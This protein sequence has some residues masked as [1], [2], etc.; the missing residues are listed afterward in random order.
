MA[1]T[2]DPNFKRIGKTIN[3]S[4]S[5]TLITG[6]AA[7]YYIGF[8][9]LNYRDYDYDARC[10]ILRFEQTC[11]SQLITIASDTGGIVAISDASNKLCIF[12]SGNDIIL[13]H[14]FTDNSNAPIPFVAFIRLG[15]L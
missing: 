13:K 7:H 12:K 3:H 4:A 5:I 9:E 8:I 14:N 1:Y 10:A 11:G 6:V 2:T 15:D